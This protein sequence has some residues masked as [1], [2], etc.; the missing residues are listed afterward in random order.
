MK[1]YLLSIC[2][3]GTQGEAPPRDVL[4]KI[5]QNVIAVRNDMKA[6]GA[7]VF[8]GGLEAPATATVLRLDGDAVL[9]TD[10]PFVEAKEYIGGLTIVRVA[11]ADA[12]HEW[13]RQLARA[14]GLPIE[15]RPFLEQ[16]LC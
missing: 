15:V 14:I 13:G 11:D 2:H 12:A 3:P 6:A 7:W 5:M 4:D 9:A 16:H 10:G 1:H 8:S